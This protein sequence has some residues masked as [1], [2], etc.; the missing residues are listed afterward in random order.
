MNTPIYW[1]ENEFPGRIA[2][3]ARPRGGDWLE[4]EIAAFKQA[5]IDVIISLLEKAE[6]IDLD[7]EREKEIAAERGLQFFSF[8]IVDRGVPNSKT[9]TLEFLL[10]LKNLLESGKNIGI[11]CRQSVG[12]SALIAAGLFAFFGIEPEKAFRQLSIARGLTV[13]ETAEQK[14]WLE[15]F[16]SELALSV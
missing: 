14:K 9:E 12:R 15:N 11:H 8:P 10:R 7:L 3:V 2:I 5:G 13:P 1:T 16:A 6:E 4:D